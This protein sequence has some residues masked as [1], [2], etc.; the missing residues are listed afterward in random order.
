MA[1]AETIAR[2]EK[3]IWVLAYGGLILLVLGLSTTR[4]DMVTGWVM[5]VAGGL[6]ALAGFVLIPIRARM[7]TS[8]SA[9]SKPTSTETE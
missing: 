1:T 3:L 6:I 2:I 5:V 8:D 7:R 4:L 9:Q